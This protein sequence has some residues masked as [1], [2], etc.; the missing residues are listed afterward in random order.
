MPLVCLGSTYPLENQE[1][2]PL[3]GQSDWFPGILPSQADNLKVLDT[4]RWVMPER[5]RNDYHDGLKYMIS[6]RGYEW[7]LVVHQVN[8]PTHLD[9]AEV[10]WRGQH[11]QRP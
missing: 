9:P 6:A 5:C 1:S 7:G 3:F 11:S 10:K 8:R 4:A 2:T